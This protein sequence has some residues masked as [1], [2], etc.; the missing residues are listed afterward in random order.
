VGLLKHSRQLPK[1]PRQFHRKLT[2][3]NHP[4][5]LAGAFA[6]NIYIT[7]KT[8]LLVSITIRAPMEHLSNEFFSHSFHINVNKN[9]CS[10]SRPPYRKNIMFFISG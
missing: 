6:I 1:L 10:P 5:T 4:V 8:V 3:Y 2:I 9:L 7:H